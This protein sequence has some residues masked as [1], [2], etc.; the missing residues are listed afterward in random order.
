MYSLWSMSLFRLARLGVGR[1]RREIGF[2]VDHVAQRIVS[3][4]PADR[5][6]DH[7]IFSTQLDFFRFV[8]DHKAFAL[9]QRVFHSLQTDFDFQY[10]AAIRHRKPK[11]S[12][13]L[14]RAPGPE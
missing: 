12:V 5:P 9:A 4:P 2:A 14:G 11:Y 3:S 7:G 13:V 10:L 6:H 1:P 8:A